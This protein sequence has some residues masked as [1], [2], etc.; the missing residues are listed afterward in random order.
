M[1]AF[2]WTGGVPNVGPAAPEEICGDWIGANGATAGRIGNSN[3]AG[4]NQFSTGSELC[5]TRHPVFCLSM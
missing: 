1:E 4:I 2:V 3:F 5:G